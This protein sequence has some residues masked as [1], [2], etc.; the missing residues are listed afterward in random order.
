MLIVLFNLIDVPM[1]Y[2]SVIESLSKDARRKF[3]VVETSF[4]SRWY[5]TQ[6]RAMQQLIG[7]FVSTGTFVSFLLV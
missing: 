1:I 3:I 5:N 7:R 6:P 4:F 2:N